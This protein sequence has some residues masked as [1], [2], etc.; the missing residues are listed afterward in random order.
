MIATSEKSMSPLEKRVIADV[1]NPVFQKCLKY[2]RLTWVK[3]LCTPGF[4]PEKANDLSEEGLRRKLEETLNLYPFLTLLVA[5]M[6]GA[7]ERDFDVWSE[8]VVNADWLGRQDLLAVRLTG[9]ELNLRISENRPDDRAVGFSFYT[10]PLEGLSIVAQ[11]IGV[12]ALEVARLWLDSNQEIRSKV[13]GYS[14]YIKLMVDNLNRCSVRTIEVKEV[15]GEYSYTSTKFYFDE[16]DYLFKLSKETTKHSDEVADSFIVGWER[17]TGIY[18]LH[19]Y[20]VVE[21]VTKEQS[22]VLESFRDIQLPL[23]NDYI[24]NN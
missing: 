6:K 19:K 15:D 23:L 1:V 4:T 12:V 8:E 14:N 21:E 9:A 7:L 17:K 10:K 18:T 5:K 20:L 2:G 3:S 22:D 11:H 13:E 24:S 16:K